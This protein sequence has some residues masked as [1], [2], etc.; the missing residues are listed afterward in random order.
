MILEEFDETIVAALNPTDFQKRD[1]NFP[2]TV[3]AF[4]HHDL[5]D[6]FV[7]VYK[8]IVIKTIS[9][10]TKDF[11]IYKITSGGEEIAV[12]QAQ[13]GAPYCTGIFEEVIALGAKSLFFA[14]SCGCLDGSI[15]DYG[16]IL[17]TSAIRDE[18]TSYHYAEPADEI[19]LDKKV[20]SSVESTLKELGIGYVKCKTWTTDGLYRETRKKVE[21]RKK[22]GAKVVDMECSALCAMAKFR[23]VDFGELFYAADDLSKSVYDPRSLVDGEIS[24]Q[25]VIIPI[26]IKC[27]ENWQR[28]NK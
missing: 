27:A 21:N 16:I 11:D 17:P 25:A 5:M 15:E 1:E 10:C 28:E 4:F 26:L 18:G 6:E 2:K 12:M 13:L 9:S 3:V 19:E 14:G 22:M 20:I 23:G 24:K 8:P 7:K